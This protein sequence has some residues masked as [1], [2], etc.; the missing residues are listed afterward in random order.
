MRNL[1]YKTTATRHSERSEEPLPSIAFQLPI[2]SVKIRL[3]RLICGPKPTA[4]SQIIMF[5]QISIG[6]SEN[7]F[8]SPIQF[9]MQ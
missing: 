7:N 4:N 5:H 9:R 6:R 2:H 1:R 3:T 8:V